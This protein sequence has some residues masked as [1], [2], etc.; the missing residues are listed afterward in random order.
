MF[1]VNLERAGESAKA[2]LS[3]C[4]GPGLGGEGV[5]QRVIGGGERC[6]AV[7]D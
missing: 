2:S 5:E 7:I 4:E 6:D 3:R 1:L